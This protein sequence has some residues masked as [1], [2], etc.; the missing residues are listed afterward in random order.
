MAS[1]YDD[2]DNGASRR[3][4][5][6]VAMYLLDL[7]M[8][9]V[10][11]VAAGAMVLTLLAPY[12]NPDRWWGFPVLG[13]AAPA[14][15]LVI[16]ALALY[17]IVRWRWIFAGAMLLLVFVGLFKVSLFYKPEFKRYYGDS[18]PER[19]SFT[20]LTYNVRLF[21]D[22]DGD[23]CAGRI[24]RLIEAHRPD[25]LCL[26]EYNARLAEASPEFRSL[27]D[28]YD[29]TFGGEDD[30]QDRS[31]VIWSRYRILRS[32]TIEPHASIWAD[33]AVG[34]DTV[35]VFC[36]H[37]RSTAI[38]SSDDAFI[39][40]HQ[41]LSDT[42]REVKLRSIVQRFRENSVLRAAQVDSIARV[43]GSAPRTKIVCG[44][45]NDTP[46]SYVYRRMAEGLSDA[47]RVCGRGYSHTFRGFY[48]TLRIDYVLV[49]PQLEPQAYEVFDEPLSD[50]LP[51]WVRLK[52]TTD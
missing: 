2:F 51:V 42:A 3:P 52:K 23:D 34:E 4:R 22:D 24:A 37:L 8:G 39:T 13:L 29:R 45:F 31:L 17:W 36:N 28:G 30:V 40:Q 50:H 19:G 44:D 33:L 43:I 14:V 48:N 25:I 1:Y 16:V 12:V 32:G 26:Q 9:F 27:A 20:V 35:R 38:K 18:G 41:Y 15:Y 49:S 5:R 21:Y 10:T 46:M 47:F 7:L 11:A 6:S